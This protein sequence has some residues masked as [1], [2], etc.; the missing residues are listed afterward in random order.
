VTTTEQM[1]RVLLPEFGEFD[2]GRDLSR[3]F[4]TAP[5]SS[6]EESS[7]DASDEGNLVFSK[8]R[9][10]KIGVGNQSNLSTAES[11]RK[12][13]A[14]TNQNES[15]SDAERSRHSLSSTKQLLNSEVALLQAT[16]RN[17]ELLLTN[18]Q[19]ELHEQSLKLAQRGAENQLLK[20]QIINMNEAAAVI[21]EQHAIET[22][23]YLGK[24]LDA[25]EMTLHA[26]ST[27]EL[28]AKAH[29]A[30]NAAQRA[31]SNSRFE[32]SAFKRDKDRLI[33]LLSLFEPAKA[34]VSQLQRI[35]SHYFPLQGIGSSAVSSITR[36][37]LTSTASNFVSNKILKTLAA[38]S[39]SWMSSKIANVVLGWG[40]ENKIGDESILML[41]IVELN[42]LWSESAKQ[43]KE[44][45]SVARL[46][47]PKT[48]H[49]TPRDHSTIGD[50]DDTF[51]SSRKSKMER[52]DK[53]PLYSSS[54]AS[55]QMAHD[56]VRSSDWGQLLESASHSLRM[57]SQNRVND[58]Q[59]L[60]R[61]HQ[62][63]NASIP[64][65]E[66]YYISPHSIRSRE[67]HDIVPSD[68]LE[69]LKQEMVF[70]GHH[71]AGGHSQS[72]PQ[73]QKVHAPLEKSTIELRNTT[74]RISLLT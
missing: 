27:L 58:D 25:E 21:A 10:R 63:L 14:K 52:R 61:S 12:G 4:S 50:P 48:L 47:K 45:T 40:T 2:K 44:V 57:H 5:A 56:S 72:S 9:I 36:I 30:A 53:Q 42:K 74:L 13:F 1:H 19:Q 38:E 37:Q 59:M 66:D 7:L 24:V 34:L 33:H 70:A 46:K 32:N 43:V 15:P 31:A 39:M 8:H 41:L 28:A 17:M 22:Q 64:K 35:P 26:A 65:I 62:V 20:D 3:L 67:R 68:L 73:P 49:S 71:S 11:N 16:I 55:Q 29:E 69:S 51:I 6:H 18:T 54:P 23:R 60:P